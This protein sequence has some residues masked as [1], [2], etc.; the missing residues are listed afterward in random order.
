M[1]G[2]TTLSIPLSLSL[3]VVKRASVRPKKTSPS[4]AVVLLVATLAALF[5]FRDGVRLGDQSIP[6]RYKREHPK[7][8]VST[9]STG[10]EKILKKEKK[11]QRQLLMTAKFA[12][13]PGHARVHD[14]LSERRNRR[15]RGGLSR[16][17][18]HLSCAFVTFASCWACVFRVRPKPLF[19][20]RAY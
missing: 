13:A 1:M 20:L 4:R 11:D 17:G 5:V 9:R 15:L 19:N 8:F 14:G 18:K 7:R 6:N 12:S 3:S 10:G 16:N 2:S